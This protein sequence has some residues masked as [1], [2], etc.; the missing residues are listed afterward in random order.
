MRRGGVER[1]HARVRKEVVENH[2]DRKLRKEVFA[3]VVIF[4]PA[5]HTLAL[6][7]HSLR[8]RTPWHRIGVIRDVGDYILLT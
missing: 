4:A 8:C 7:A 1:A 6:R 5:W 3:L 2:F